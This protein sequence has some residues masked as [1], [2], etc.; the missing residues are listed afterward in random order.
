M[1]SDV[2]VERWKEHQ[3]AFDRVR[4][5]AVTVSEPESADRIA[6]RS[7]VAENTARD[8]LQRL[9]EMNVLQTTNGESA[10]LYAPDP[11]YTRMQALRDL[12]DGRDRDDLLEL[13]GDL[14]E[15]VEVWQDE[16][17]ADSP[18][19]LR[20][21]AAHADTAE[22]TREMRRAANDWDIIAY[23]LRLVEDAIEHYSDYTGSTP[24]PA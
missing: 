17:G 19:Y 22:G 9:V 10:T 16:H 3:S 18:G 2:G 1:V 24:A 8:H 14:Q 15:R 7:H 11:L 4:S 23:R 13:R 5:V 20:E 12:L 21:Q 6:E